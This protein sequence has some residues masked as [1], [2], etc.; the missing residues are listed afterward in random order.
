MQTALQ[1]KLAIGVIGSKP[2]SSAVYY[3]YA[4]T[5]LHQYISSDGCSVVSYAVDFLRCQRPVIFVH[6]QYPARSSSARCL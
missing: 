6:L 3:V 5:L 4:C 1:I 2:S